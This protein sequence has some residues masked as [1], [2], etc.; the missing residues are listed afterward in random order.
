MLS[1]LI[2]ITE[3]PKVAFPSFISKDRLKLENV[4]CFGFQEKLLPGFILYDYM[5]PGWMDLDVKI[6]QKKY[7]YRI[8]IK[9]TNFLSNL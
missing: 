7:R 2:Y 3:N 5:L 1:S 9:I 6:S 8:R 4:D